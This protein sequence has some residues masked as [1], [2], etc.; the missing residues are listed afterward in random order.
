VLSF[1]PIKYG[2]IYC[3]ELTIITLK[4]SLKI[5]FPLSP[6]QQMLQK[7]KRKIDQMLRKIAQKQEK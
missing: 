7:S 6:Y 3:A 4:V 1:T 2:R 5:I